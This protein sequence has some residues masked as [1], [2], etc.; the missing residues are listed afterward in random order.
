MSN[1]L[2]AVV[3]VIMLIISVIAATGIFY[4]PGF[5]EVLGTNKPRDLG[6][7]ADPAKFGAVLARE[8]V[9]LS[10]P[11]SN[12]YL[13]S[14]VRWGNAVPMEVTMTNDELSSMMQATNNEKGPLKNVQLK[15]GD[16]NQVEMSA[17]VDLNK[18]GY[19]INVPVYTKGTLVKGSGNTVKIDIKEGSSGL[20]PIPETFLNQGE[21]GLE[22]GVNKQLAQ[23]PGLKIDT[24]AISQGQLQFNG[25]F[26]QT[27]SAS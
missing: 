2:I 4:I 1:K 22:D 10:G 3:I 16:N 7:K 27:G 23:M 5:S 17:Q 18:F 15:M 20:V 13:G 26:P 8:N 25:A 6:V 14:N 24:L 12:Y 19:P 11:I 21:S 9:K